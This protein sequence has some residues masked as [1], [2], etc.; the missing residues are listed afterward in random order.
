L[1]PVGQ[2]KKE[3]RKIAMAVPAQINSSDATKLAAYMNS[4]AIDTSHWQDVIAG[5]RDPWAKMLAS[6]VNKQMARF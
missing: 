3:L 4:H 1:A 5:R 6:D 2:S